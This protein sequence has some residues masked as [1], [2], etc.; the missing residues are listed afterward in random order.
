MSMP[1]RQTPRSVGGYGAN[2]AAKEREAALRGML[3]PAA[4]HRGLAH[5]RSSVTTSDSGTESPADSPAEDVLGVAG[6]RG[7]AGQRD[8]PPVLGPVA[9]STVSMELRQVIVT[10]LFVLRANDQDGEWRDWFR[11]ER[12]QR[13]LRR[14]LGTRGAVM[15]EM[16]QPRAAGGGV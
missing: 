12:T 6:Q 8:D 9:D 5:A 15:I 16:K 2:A 3:S 13:H 4:H 7:A 10:P 14:V 1:L 11:K